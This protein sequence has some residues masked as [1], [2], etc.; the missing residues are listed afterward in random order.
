MFYL[1]FYVLWTVIHCPEHIIAQSFYSR[2]SNLNCS[3][4]L[5]IPY[6]Y[7]SIEGYCQK[8][9][10]PKYEIL[11]YFGY[12][13][14]CPCQWQLSDA[15]LNFLRVKLWK[16]SLKFSKLVHYKPE[17][18][19]FNLQATAGW[20]SVP[21]QLSLQLSCLHLKAKKKCFWG[22]AMDHHFRYRTQ[23]SMLGNQTH[24]FIHWQLTL[25]WMM[26]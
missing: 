25:L 15:I 5:Q 18:L 22:F 19:S 26:L 13:W 20:L 17:E 23:I 6:T 11:K 14:A 10:I 9:W 24:C 3:N 8:I 12:Y 16:Y 2:T 7:T 4:T 1:L 21:Y